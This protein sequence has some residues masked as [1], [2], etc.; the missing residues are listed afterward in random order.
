MHSCFEIVQ[1]DD[2][3]LSRC[4]ARHFTSFLSPDSSLRL[5]Y[6]NIVSRSHW[7]VGPK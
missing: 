1:L 3:R 2:A 5:K 4:L 6:T 7:D